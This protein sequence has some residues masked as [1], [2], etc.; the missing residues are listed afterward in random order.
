MRAMRLRSSTI[1]H[2]TMA[3]AVVAV[4]WAVVMPV[5]PVEAANPCGNNQHWGRKNCEGFYTGELASTD[6]NQGGDVVIP[7]GLENVTGVDNYIST[8][9]QFLFNGDQQE[10]TGASFTITTMMGRGPS[11]YGGNPAN[12]IKW[13]Q[14]NFDSWEKVI[15]YYQA[16]NLIDW[17][18]Y[19]TYNSPHE[20]SGYSRTI[21]D[22]YFTTYPPYGSDDIRFRM[23]PGYNGAPFLID[24]SCANIQGS[25]EPLPYPPGSPPV[26][27]PAPQAATGKTNPPTP[28]TNGN[29]PGAVTGAPIDPA[30]NS[31]CEKI[32]GTAF[33]PKLPSYA[34]KVTA[35]FSSG[36][37]SVTKTASTTGAHQFQLNTPDGV[38]NNLNAV[39]VTVKATDSAGV[40]Y[41]LTNSPIIIGPCHQIVAACVNA[42]SIPAAPDPNSNYAIKAT[43]EYGNSDDATIAAAQAD[44]K[45]YAHVT[46]PNGPAVVY[47]N[48]DIKPVT[49]A[50]NQLSVTVN[51]L[52]P[53]G[54][55]GTYQISWGATA[56]YG[57]VM[58]GYDSPSKVKQAT[59]TA[60]NKPYFKVLGADVRVGSQM[61]PG[62]GA[63]CS[64]TKNEQA[65]IV[66]WSVDP[67]SGNYGGAGTQ[68]AGIALNHI[69]EFAT[70]QGHTAAPTEP[71]GLSF[72]NSI[73]APPGMVNAPG[74]LYGGKFD[75]VDCVASYW[76]GANNSNKTAGPV[77][78][79]TLTLPQAFPAGGSIT[80]GAQ[81]IYYIEGDLLVDSDV[82]FTG[83]YASVDKV[84]KFAVIV[85]GNIFISP[86]VKRLDGFYI[87]QASTPASTDGIIFS[88]A[89]SGLATS[90]TNVLNKD[91]QSSCSTPLEVNGAFLSRQIWLLRTAGGLTTTPAETFNY[92]P[93]VW[94][95]GPF[96]GTSLYNGNDYDAISSLPPVL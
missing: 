94:L 10:K 96:G 20:D 72:A 50:G 28:S 56:T 22:N 25:D 69:Q 81:M 76:A 90:T 29:P 57:S 36:D 47:D 87:A 12:G 51:N 53:L 64:I 62:I 91:L 49:R 88:C 86:T 34:V 89:P 35:S 75:G 79:S 84:P 73:V 14:D 43:I 4:A 7:A 33:D 8:M 6:K 39:T 70:A 93:D 65:S 45:F 5:H 37:P 61:S 80:N 1:W 15:R 95:R 42:T 54:K 78:L 13:A 40:D 92:V 38:R 48:K 16:N 17:K 24:R 23:P 41:A 66:G 71:S 3:I 68:F 52:P 60:L 21:K 82:K 83:N 77:A 11:F 27:P 31:S 9:K 74:G 46:G 44:F 18:Y 2:Y 67:L 59:V 55:T 58:C 32:T 30:V 63:N 19:I 26:T 85:K